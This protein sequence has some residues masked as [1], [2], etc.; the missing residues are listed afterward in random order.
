MTFEVGDRVVI[1]MDADSKWN[2]TGTVIEKMNSH[3]LIKIDHD[4]QGI[5]SFFDRRLTL[6]QSRESSETRAFGYE[7]K[8]EQVDYQWSSERFTA[9]EQRL[10]ELDTKGWEIMEIDLKDSIL[11]A[12]RAKDV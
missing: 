5:A 2:G 10:N 3:K 8:V 12:R 4:L 1:T 11:T 7:Y 6:I 9:L